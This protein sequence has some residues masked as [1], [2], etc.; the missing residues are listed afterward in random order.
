M[1]EIISW[2]GMWILNVVMLIFLAKTSYV[3]YTDKQERLPMRWLRPSEKWDVDMKKNC[4]TCKFEPEWKEWYGDGA[5]R[6]PR[7]VGRCRYVVV[8]PKLPSVFQHSTLNIER[9]SD[10]SGIVTG[11][12]TWSRKIKRRV[13]K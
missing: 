2:W 13:K 1:I 11:C 6:Y 7:Q 12:P 4:L 3:E 9:Y 5:D 8:L 10:N